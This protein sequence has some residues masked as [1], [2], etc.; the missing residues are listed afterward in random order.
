MATSRPEG[1]HNG[2]IEQ[3]S[4]GLHVPVYARIDP[5]AGRR[6]GTRGGHRREVWKAPGNKLVELPANGPQT[7][8]RILG[9]EAQLWIDEWFWEAELQSSTRKAMPD[10]STVSS[11]QILGDTAL[12]KL[13]AR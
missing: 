10:T 5:V 13:G 12:K 1:R 8:V 9:G 11:S 6:T 3:R 7:A 4:K 2:Y